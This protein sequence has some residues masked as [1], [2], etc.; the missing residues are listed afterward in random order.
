MSSYNSTTSNTTNSSTDINK[1]ETDVL[2]AASKVNGTNVYN[3]QGESLGSIHDVM[4]GKRTG[5]VVYAVLSF[6][7]FLGM[8]QNYHPVP[9]KKL[10]YSERFGGYMINL[11]KQQLEAAPAY[12][13]S[14]SPDW[15]NN[16]YGNSVDKYY[17]GMPTT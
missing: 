2:I 12:G 3:M 8:G 6:G 13:V 5:Q 11:D 1:K 15:S 17:D 4:L 14:D 16:A 10:T 9:W 7:G